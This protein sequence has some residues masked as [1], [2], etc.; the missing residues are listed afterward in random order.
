MGQARNKGAR[1]KVRSASLALTRELVFADP[2]PVYHKMQQKCGPELERAIAA[3]TSAH[4]VLEG[5]TVSWPRTRQAGYVRLYLHSALNNLILA[6]HFLSAGY[7]Q[8]AGNQ[9]RSYA[10]ASAMALLLLLPD[11]WSA[12]DRARQRYKAHEALHRVLRGKNRKRLRELVSL[13]RDRWEAFVEVAKFYDHHSHA[14]M[15]SLASHLRLDTM[16]PILGGE[17]DPAKRDEYQADLSRVASGADALQALITATRR[18]LGDDA[19]IM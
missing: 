9:V 1:R 18:A 4:L 7:L 2:S 15:V 5:L 3:I 14:G 16:S 13:D 12:F 19:T 6:T 11:E 8:P 10:E 17:Y